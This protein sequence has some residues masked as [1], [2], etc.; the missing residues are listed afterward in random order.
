MPTTPTIVSDSYFDNYYSAD[1]GGGNDIYFSYTYYYGNGDFYQGYGYGDNSL[2]YYSGQYKYTDEYGYYNYNETYNYGYYYIDYVYDYGYDLG[3]S[4]SNTNI[5]VSSYYDG[6]GDYDGVGTPSYTYAYVSSGVGYYGLG[7]EYGYAYNS[8]YSNSDSYFDNY[9]SADTGGGNDIYFSYTYYYGNGDFYQ[10]YGYGDNSLGYYSGQYKY[11]DEYGYY[12]YNE[13]YNYGYYYID[14]VY[15]YG[16]DAYGFTGSNTNIYVSSYYD[17]GGDYDGVDSPSYTYAY[18][19]SGVGYYGLGSEYGYAYNS[20]YSNS[21]SY[22]DN[23][24]SAD[25]GGGNNDIYF[26]YTYYYGNGD[27]Y[28]GYGYGDNSLGYY[29]GQYKYTDEYGY[30]NYNETYNYGYYY[31]DYVYDYGYDLG[32]SGSNTNIYVSS[33]YDGGGDYDGVGTPVTPMP[34]CRLGSVIMV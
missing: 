8:D 26:S 13:T 18:V 25:T 32:Y 14:Y 3:Y 4:G 15:D 24:Y 27:F 29:S 12:N 7:S 16:Y 20:D 2:G 17:G 9:Y 31:I 21:D 34:M 11:T 23:Y 10:G 33:Y 22:F 6:G 28:Q 19:S 5:Y 30:Y 1:T